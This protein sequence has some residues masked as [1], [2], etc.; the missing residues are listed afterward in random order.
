MPL[1]IWEGP[2]NS[3]IF[4]FLHFA[5]LFRKYSKL[6]SLVLS[7]WLLPY[8]IAKHKIENI[9]NHWK[10]FQTFIDDCSDEYSLGISF[11]KSQNQLSYRWKK[12]PSCKK[13][14]TKRVRKKSLD[15]H[16]FFELRKCQTD[17]TW[18]APN[19]SFRL[20]FFRAERFRGNWDDL[21]TYS[22]VACLHIAG[23]IKDRLFRHGQY[24][25]HT[26]PPF[27]YGLEETALT[28]GYLDSLNLKILLNY[29]F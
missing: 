5:T 7:M 15:G 23:G 8:F 22:F 13:E 12:I 9:T 26:R 11:F 27:F 29:R 2:T 24:F 3:F 25:M 6:M 21:H 14:M 19:W 1:L 17:K 18:M 10:F 20:N 16:P 4:L 28:V